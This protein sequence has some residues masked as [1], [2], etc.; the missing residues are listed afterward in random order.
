MSTMKLNGGYAMIDLSGTDLAA[1]SKVTITGIY[2][3]LDTA[4]KS[5]KPI[6]AHNVVDGVKKI[7]PTPV[8]VLNN[9]GDLEATLGVS[10]I[11]VDSD[12]GVTISSLVTANRTA[13]K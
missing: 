1:G 11:T 5:G 7:S 10:K 2:K 6:I 12:D 13:K 4:Y 8:P 9:S 3:I